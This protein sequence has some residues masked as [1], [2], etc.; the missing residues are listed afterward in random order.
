MNEDKIGT[1]SIIDGKQRMSAIHEFMTGKLKLAKLHVFPEINELRFN[2]MPQH[3]QRLIRTRL[4]I[5]SI[6]ILNQSDPY[7]KYDVFA[8]LNTGGI[9]LNAQ[10]VRNNAFAGPLNDKIMELSADKTFHRLLGITVPRKSKLWQEM[11]DAEY[12]L[13]FLTFKDFWREYSGGMR[14]TMDRFMDGNRSASSDIL[15]R[16]DTEFRD[17]V[18]K[19]DLVFGDKAYRRFNPITKEYRSQPVASIFDAQMFS[20]MAI[21]LDRASQQRDIIRGRFEGLF[22]DPEF[23]R[24]IDAA[25]NT[26]SFFKTRIELALQAAG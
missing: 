18:T 3:F 16:W 15:D 4:N 5:R 21:S 20:L 8:R 17:T 7:I 22:S 12:V 11:R 13:R 25:T 10:E 26:P 14:V 23:S 6:I 1:Y 24:S 9:Q 19:V 2:E